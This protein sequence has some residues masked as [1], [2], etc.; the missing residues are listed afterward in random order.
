MIDIATG[1]AEKV[2]CLT[3]VEFVA[4]EETSRRE[5]RL[6]ATQVLTPRS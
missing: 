4:G 1:L 2:D 6:I 3:L 5:T